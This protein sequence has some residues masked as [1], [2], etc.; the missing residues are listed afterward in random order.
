MTEKKLLKIDGMSCGHCQK[1]VTGLLKNNEGVIS[2]EVDL[3]NKTAQVE[4]DSEKISIQ[5]IAAAVNKSEIYH[6]EVC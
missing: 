6:A 5:T 2:A 3:A 4:F 1:T